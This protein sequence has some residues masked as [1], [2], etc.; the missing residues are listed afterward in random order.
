M[1]TDLA[2]AAV[3]KLVT[4]D[5][6][7]FEAP[8]DVLRLSKTINTMLQSQGIDSESSDQSLRP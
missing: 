1:S 8:V 6:E 2:N 5:G 4:N 7:I 3:T